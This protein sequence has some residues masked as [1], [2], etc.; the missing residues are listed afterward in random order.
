M[1]LLDYDLDE[2]NRITQKLRRLEGN[3]SEDNENSQDNLEINPVKTEFKPIKMS[4][5]KTSLPNLDVKNDASEIKS[6][7]LETEFNNSE[8][9]FNNLQ[10]EEDKEILKKKKHDSDNRP[11]EA[12]VKKIK[13]ILEK[14]KKEVSKILVGQEK[15][16]N[17]LLMG[18][19]CN[20]HV[21][22]EGVPGIAKTLAIRA[23][24]AVSGCKVSRIQFTVD[25]L[26]TDIVGI[27]SYTPGKG[28]EVI[29]GPVFSNFLI[30]DE[31]NRSP[32]KTQ[33]ALMEAMQERQ[34]T[35]GKITYPI[36]EPFFVMATENPLENAGV[37]PLP[38]AQVDRFLFKVIM[39]Y[40]TE[41]EE[42]LIMEQNMT[43]QKF[44]D[45][46]LK[47][48][49]STKEIIHMQNI[50]K[51][52]YLDDNIK[53][54]ILKIIK[55]TRNKNFKDAE[56]LSFGGSPRAS[57][58]MYI[59]S[60]ARALMEGRN[61]VIPEDV[62]A[63]V[64]EVLRHRLILSYKAILKQISPDILIKNILDEIEII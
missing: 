38:E 16:V 61:Y 5:I 1:K 28:F 30:A 4:P 49:T 34:A 63:I 14:V 45:F 35:I 22:I 32:P 33:S 8:T 46:N 12:E 7:I 59:A 10:T 56:Y 52:V 19:L 58:A 18:L 64:F 13:L 40:P 60:K 39:D 41:K 31:I 23:L 26:P 48:V 36:S 25:L 15:I 62:K 53:D 57:I 55:K 51:K 27:T 21:L 42:K 44:E 47:A 20:G 24:G 6:N 17:G 29:K 11:S 50:I 3:L 9:E 54:Y 37:Y 43:L 2:E